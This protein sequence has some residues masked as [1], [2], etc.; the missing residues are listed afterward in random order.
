ML[1]Q[2][3]LIFAKKTNF[4][5]LLLKLGRDGV[6]VKLSLWSGGCKIFVVGQI[7]SLKANL[8]FGFESSDL[9]QTGT[10]DIY[11]RSNPLH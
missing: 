10:T 5:A 1:G 6:K 8:M 3:L 4:R 9:T 7:L 11:V 2:K